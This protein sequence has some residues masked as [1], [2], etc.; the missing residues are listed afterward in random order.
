MKTL[1]LLLLLFT[2]SGCNPYKEVLQP[3]KYIAP[4]CY[5]RYAAMAKH[6]YNCKMSE[7]LHNKLDRKVAHD[8]S[9]VLTNQFV[10]EV[11]MNIRERDRKKMCNCLELRIREQRGW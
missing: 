11:Q 7:L 8:S 1:L 10:A 9:V 4:N 3:I 2:L 6:Y 5:C